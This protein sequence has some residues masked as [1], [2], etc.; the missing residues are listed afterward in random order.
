[1]GKQDEYAY[2]SNR[3]KYYQNYFDKQTG[4]MRGKV[5]ATEWRT[6][7]SPF[8]SR[9]E[10]DD[11][12]EG[13]A[14]QYTWLVPED[15]E[16]LIAL[17]GGDAGFIKKLDSLFIVKGDL[18][19]EAS[20]DISG[21]IGQYAHGNEPSHHIAYLYTFAGQPWKTQEKARQILTEFYTIKPDGI[22]GNEDVGQM[23]AWYVLSAMGIYQENPANGKYIFGSPVI[24]DAVIKLPGG[25]NFHIVVMNNSSTNKYISNV[26]LINRTYTLNYLL[27]GQLAIRGLLEITMSDKP[28]D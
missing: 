8:V 19:K 27:H 9:H 25:K 18:G 24:N 2:I 3:A 15:V 21:L 11:Y 16:G 12:T 26:T 7:F 14:W 5:S 22:I 23:S 13:N 20:P 6:P 10:K 17:H 28:G 4:F 1:M